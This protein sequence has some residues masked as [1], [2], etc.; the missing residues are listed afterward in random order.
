M[1]SGE[2]PERPAGPGPRGEGRRD[3]VLHHR[4][5]GMIEFGG[6]FLALKV[7]PQAATAGAR[8]AGA[9]QV[10]SRR[11]CGRN[12]LYPR[13]VPR[14]ATGAT[15]F[16]PPSCEVRRRRVHKPSI[17]ISRGRRVQRQSATGGSQGREPAK[18][19][20]SR[21]DSRQPKADISDARR[22][23]SAGKRGVQGSRLAATLLLCPRRARCLWP[24]PYP[25]DR[26]LGGRPDPR[27]LL[28][29]AFFP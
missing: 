21:V 29:T 16:A 12:S 20:R 9:L 22:R 6:A 18:P 19:G 28:R 1:F 27:A 11:T 8:A 3:R 26:R 4:G 17:Q 23:A 5:G 13:V 7:I 10:G 14:D 24:Y 25:R 15:R 2:V